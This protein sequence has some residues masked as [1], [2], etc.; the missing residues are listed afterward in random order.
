[1]K[2]FVAVTVVLISCSCAARLGRVNDRRSAQLTSET[3]RLAGI[4][5]PLDRIQHY[6]RISQLLIGSVG[7]AARENNY[8]MMGTLLD[9]Y[10]EVLRSAEETLVHSGHDP[11]EEPEGF[12]DLELALREEARRLQDITRSLRVDDRPSVEVA[13]DTAVSIR[14]ELLRLI[15]PQAAAAKHFRH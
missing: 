1:M 15:F 7:E 13:L 6:I 11:A 4:K 8:E 14:E 12:T 2:Y 10:V 3:R 9:E 5:D